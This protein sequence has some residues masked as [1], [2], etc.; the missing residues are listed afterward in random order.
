V[1]AR[2]ASLGLVGALGFLLV[3]S[4]VASAALSALSDFINAR[5][6]FGGVILVGLNW[7]ISF[8]LLSLLF[9]AIYKVLPDRNLQWR[10]VLVGAVATAVLFTIGK[11]LIGAYLGS[12]AIGSSYGAAGALL[13]VLLW[14]YYSSEVFLLG[15]EFTRAWSVRHG[16]RP[17]RRHPELKP[18]SESAG[19][20]ADAVANRGGYQN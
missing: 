15:A 4:L 1:R 18:E 2:A 16:S 19:H 17:D 12:S 9:A 10:D 13:I 20:P 14:V 5:L 8:V 11:S 7:S 6:P 3:V